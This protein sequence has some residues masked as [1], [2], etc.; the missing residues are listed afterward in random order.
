MCVNH[1]LICRVRIINYLEEK[2][3]TD[4]ETVEI[5]SLNIINFCLSQLICENAYWLKIIT[6]Y[7]VTSTS[8]CVHIN[9]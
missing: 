4:I 3:K 8:T 6:T 1:T 2:Q 5:Y 9:N 7:Q